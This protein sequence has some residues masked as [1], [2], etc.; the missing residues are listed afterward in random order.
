MSTTGRS[1]RLAALNRCQDKY[2]TLKSQ[3]DELSYVMQGSVVLR[4]KQC[5]QPDCRCHLG[6]EHEHGPYYQWTRKVNAKTV[7]KLLSPAEARVYQ[8]FIRN[9][10]RLKK[11]LARMY[12][13]SARA[14][15]YLA[16]DQAQ[17]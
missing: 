16:E 5:G 14:A 6:P 17:P 1:R 7:T 10:R 12:E 3:I 8:D 11:L 9:G 15:R 4:T 2:E 13:I